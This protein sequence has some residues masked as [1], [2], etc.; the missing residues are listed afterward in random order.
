[1]NAVCI[2]HNSPIDSSQKI[3]GSHSDLKFSIQACHPSFSRCIPTS[4][5]VCIH[6]LPASALI[7]G[8][9]PQ[10]VQAVLQ[11]HSESFKAQAQLALVLGLPEMCVPQVFANPCSDTV[12][13]TT[14]PKMS[15]FPPSPPSSLPIPYIRNISWLLKCFH[16]MHT[17]KVTARWWVC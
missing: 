15:A 4:V 3:S 10:W 1:M 16:H 5:I 11:V 9:K 13:P 17:Q 8:L 7:A 14:I 6:F 2:K 12:S